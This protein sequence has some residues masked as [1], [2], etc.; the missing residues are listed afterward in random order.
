MAALAPLDGRGLGE[1]R[2]VVGRALRAILA[3]DLPRPGEV[4]ATTLSTAK[5]SGCTLEKLTLSRQGTG[6]EVPALLLVPDAWT[7]KVVVAVSDRGKDSLLGA[8]AGGSPSPFAAAAVAARAAV[9]APDVFLTGELA[10]AGKEPRPPVDPRRHK[11]WFGYTLG[12]NRTVLANRAHDV[13]TAIGH[14]RSLPGAHTVHLAGFGDAGLWAIL[15]RGLAGGAVD[16]T[17]AARPS[18]DF[19]DVKDADDPRLLPGGVK[20]GGWGAFAALAAP[21]DLWLIGEGGPPPALAAAY[22]AGAVEDRLKSFPAD[23]APA[24]LLKSLLE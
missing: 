16:R 18:F 14:A 17:L 15:A 9:L 6:E 23:A 21:G 1:Y 3:S 10:P 13:L 5:G 19:A 22:R 8:A 4:A 11:D 20:Y 7:G 24:D 2:R 12:Y